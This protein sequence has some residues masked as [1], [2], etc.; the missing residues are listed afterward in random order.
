MPFALSRV[1]PA[2]NIAILTKTTVKKSPVAI[3]INP[4]AS[5]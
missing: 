5:A 4:V 2:A 1:R 3:I